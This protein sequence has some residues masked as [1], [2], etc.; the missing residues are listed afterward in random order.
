RSP[1]SHAIAIMLCQLRKSWHIFSIFPSLLEY[2]TLSSKFCG[3]S[4]FCLIC[5]T[6]QHRIIVTK[7]A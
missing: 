1:F 7:L 5:Y 4:F 6:D 3:S 2:V